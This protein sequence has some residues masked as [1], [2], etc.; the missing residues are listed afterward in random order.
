MNAFV[1]LTDKAADADPVRVSLST[2]CALD[3]EGIEVRLFIC[4]DWLEICD[5]DRPVSAP[6][7]KEEVSEVPCKICAQSERKHVCSI[8][9]MTESSRCCFQAIARNTM[10]MR[11]KR[12]DDRYWVAWHF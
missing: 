1:S 9:K 3:F 10:C 5:P 6:A 12:A 4:V 7:D 8:L 11:A 2:R